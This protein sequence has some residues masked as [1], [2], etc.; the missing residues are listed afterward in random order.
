MSEI[1][2]GT[3]R[4]VVQDYNNIL[5]ALQRKIPSPVSVAG[6]AVRDTILGRDIRD[7]DIF[8]SDAHTDAAA[9]LLR[10]EFGYVKVGQW[11]RYEQ[12]SDPAVARATKFE[13]AD[14]II[15]VCLIVWRRYSP[16][17]KISTALTLVSACAAWQG[18][19]TSM[20][21]T[22]QFKR[23]AEAKTF[24]LCRADDLPQFTYS[25][26]RFQ[27]LTADRYKDFTLSVPRQ[28]EELAREH[29]FRKHWYIGGDGAHFGIESEALQALRPKDR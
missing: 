12:F 16:R 2:N 14:E 9:A 19:S 10:S 29:A 18:G 21:T 25:M 17:G 6:G 13:K 4:K 27:K 1:S 26:V 28:F 23:D 20:F 3:V 8:L 22:D 7:V 11:V 15:P 5:E 24:T